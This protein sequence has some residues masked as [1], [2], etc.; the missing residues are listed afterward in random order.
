M[1]VESLELI[2]ERLKECG[3][4]NLSDIASISFAG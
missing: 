3:K 2:L 1:F 4:L